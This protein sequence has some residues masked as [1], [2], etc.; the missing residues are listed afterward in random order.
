MYPGRVLVGV[1]LG[2]VGFMSGSAPEQIEIGV[3][4]AL[5]GE[6]DVQKYRMLD[7]RVEGD[8][9]S[10]LAASEAA[11]LKPHPRRTC[12]VEV[13]VEGETF[14]GFRCDGF[15]AATPLGSTAYALSAAGPI[16]SGDV[17]C[18]LLTAI[19][20]HS[21]ANRPLVV[22]AN[23]TTELYVTERAAYLSVD[24][25]EPR[26]VPAGGLVEVRLSKESVKIGRT[27]EWGWWQV[28]RRTFL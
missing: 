19:A 7:V 12:S 2:R 15:I 1:D 18:Y 21:L 23:Q 13:C 9:A 6:L 10:M 22:G 20:P 27:E 17:S 3:E 28:V 8:E 24:G 16:V 26:R 11:L 5:G 14:F 25:V 4:K